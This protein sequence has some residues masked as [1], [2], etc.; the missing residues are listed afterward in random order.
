MPIENRQVTTTF[1]W[2]ECPVCGYRSGD[3][4]GSSAPE[5]EQ[6]THEPLCARAAAIGLKPVF[7]DWLSGPGTDIK[8]W[9]Y[10][11]LFVS[12]SRESES[13][14]EGQGD[15]AEKKT[16]DFTVIRLSRE[17]IARKMYR[18]P[19]HDWDWLDENAYIPWLEDVENPHMG[20]TEET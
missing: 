12:F 4:V 11:G 3:Y 5:H 14:W 1:Y 19:G 17:G 8:G 9:A 2:Y 6:K 18:V 20:K 10:E 7:R 15:E 13:Y 16:R